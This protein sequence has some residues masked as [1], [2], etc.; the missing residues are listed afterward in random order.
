MMGNSDREDNIKNEIEKIYFVGQDK[1]FFFLEL[2]ENKSCIKESK[3]N[4]LLKI[5]DISECSL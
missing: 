2:I 5:Y 4:D 3:S 1:E